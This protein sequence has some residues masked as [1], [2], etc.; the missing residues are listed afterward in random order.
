M[1]SRFSGLEG[2]K[3]YPYLNTK[4]CFTLLKFCMKIG[5]IQFGLRLMLYHSI[6][7]AQIGL[8]IADFIFGVIYRKKALD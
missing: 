2:K 7:L 4:S 1:V 3:R 5:R 8:R 6:K